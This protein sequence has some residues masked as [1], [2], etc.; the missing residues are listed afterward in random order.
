MRIVFVTHNELGRVCIEQLAEMGADIE[1]IYTRPKNDE[2]ADQSEIEETADR[3]STPIH[4][5]SS[6][7]TEPVKE[8]IAAYA[9]D[10]LFIVGWSRL[11]EQSMLEIPSVAALGMHPAPLPR[12]RGRAPIAW[13]LI[14]G[15]DETALSFFHLVEAADAG[16]LVGQEPVPIDRTDDASSLYQKIVETGPQLIESYYPKFESGEIPRK[17][18]DDS[19]A[20][21]WPKREPHHGLIDWN[22]TPERV[23]NWI[24]GQTR[25]YPGALSY[26]NG[27]KVTVWAADPPEE[28]RRWANPGEVL[29]RDDG[30]VG[31]GV[32]EGVIE[33]TEVE[34]EGESGP[35]GRIFGKYN[36][37]TGDIFENARMNV[38]E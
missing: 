25:P 31:V 19:E 27:K 23:Y 14:K 36:V 33:L 22:Q 4:R 17:P 18:Q 3:L 13:S 11:V 10:L 21:W 24:R 12:G 1:A 6:V 30:T 28:R 26:V 37:S 38:A 32:W 5:V 34:I 7:N 9:P 2:I 15:L 8:E 20:T 16:D 35:A 29:F